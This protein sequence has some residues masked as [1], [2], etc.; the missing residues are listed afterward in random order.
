[1]M[2]PAFFAYILI[3]MNQM[4]AG[5]VMYMSVLLIVG[6]IDLQVKIDSYNRGNLASAQREQWTTVVVLAGA[7]LVAY[8]MFSESK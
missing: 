3:G 4:C 7:D 6:L 5:Y 2:A 8:S 1:M